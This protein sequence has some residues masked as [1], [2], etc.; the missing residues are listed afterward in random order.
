MG[1]QAVPNYFFDLTTR[2]CSSVSTTSLDDSQR[3]RDLQQLNTARPWMWMSSRYSSHLSCPVGMRL[4]WPP[5]HSVLRYRKPEQLLVFD[6][7]CCPLGGC[8]RSWSHSL[9]A[10]RVDIS[11]KTYAEIELHA[12]SYDELEAERVEWQCAG[13]CLSLCELLKICE[14]CRST[15]W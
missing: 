10:L 2:L 15:W 3:Q 8:C 6:N 1:C 5:M 14:R 7:S 12:Q 4:R 9:W 11:G 13:D